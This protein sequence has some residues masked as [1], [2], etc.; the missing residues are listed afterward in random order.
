[1]GT[2]VG[3]SIENGFQKKFSFFQKRKA[4]IIICNL[5]QSDFKSSPAF[6]KEEKWAK[7]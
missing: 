4:M 7:F 3:D 6:W 2:C 1:M 5:F